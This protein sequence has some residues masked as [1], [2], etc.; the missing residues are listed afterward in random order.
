MGAPPTEVFR[1]SNVLIGGVFAGGVVAFIVGL[2]VR[3][4]KNYKRY[5]FGLI[6]VGLL[7]GLL[8]VPGLVEEHITI[9]AHDYSM[10]TGFWF[11]PNERRFAFK[12]VE[13]ITDGFWTDA[14]G[15]Q[16]KR[17]E[18]HLKSGS[19]LDVPTGDLWRSNQK[20]IIQVL[21][22]RGVRFQ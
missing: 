8:I 17:W 16:N 1:F 5:G 11:A 12:D 13:F 4:S 15:R 3:H 19:I 6:F 21:Q 22:E 2:R 10:R 20:R 18:V 7:A 9:T 14:K